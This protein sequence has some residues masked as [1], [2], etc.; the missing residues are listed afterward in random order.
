[1][2]RLGERLGDAP[3]PGEEAASRRTWAA[4]ERALAA[5][6]ARPARRRAPRLALAAAAVL[7]LVAGALALTPPGDAVAD[8][9][10]RAVAAAPPPAARPAPPRLPAA[11]RLLAEAP[12]GLWIVEADGRRRRLGR[13]VAG[14]WSPHGRFVVAVRGPRL[15]TLDRAGRVRWSLRRP[16]ALDQP[17]WAPDGRMI[18][19]RSGDGLRVVTGDGRADRLAAGPLGHAGPAWR[20]GPGYAVAWADRRGRVQL[21]DV[22]SGRPLW[23]SR[24]GRPVVRLLW[25]PSGRTLAAVGGRS[26]RLF[27][28]DGRL[29]RRIR[30]PASIEGAAFARHGSE[31]LTLALH[32]FR[33]GWSEVVLTASRGPGGLR[34]MFSGRGRMFDL[35][36]SPRGSW[37]LVAWR[38]ADEWLFL[39]SAGVDRVAAV[40]SVTRFVDPRARGLWAFPRV[41]GWCCPP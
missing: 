8:W 12:S 11:G 2:S 32:D 3:A 39:H 38:G 29:L 19:Y 25:S 24:A 20:P 22:I 26:V 18:A 40:E 31:P 33:R 34:R 28:R 15:V 13:W 36:W 35:A 37:L 21:R 30:A 41:R 27:D 14:A 5:P 1:V 23:T 6:V 7:A 17:A 10:R 16:Y 4:V 9:L